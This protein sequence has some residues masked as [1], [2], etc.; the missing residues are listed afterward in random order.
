LKAAHIQPVTHN[1]TPSKQVT[2]KADSV[3]E[4]ESDRVR[5]DSS[6]KDR[7]FEVTHPSPEARS[8]SPLQEYVDE[9]ESDEESDR[10]TP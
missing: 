3:E 1:P 2:A 10:F 6:F 8:P 5:A 9:T 7:L 4:G